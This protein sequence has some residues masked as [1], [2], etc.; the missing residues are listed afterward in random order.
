[1]YAAY[2][3]GSSVVCIYSTPDGT[4]NL[5]LYAMIGGVLLVGLSLGPY[6]EVL[7]I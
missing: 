7:G 4:Y 5:H 1:M 2:L 6:F 3:N